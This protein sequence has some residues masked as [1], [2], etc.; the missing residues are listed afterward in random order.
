MLKTIIKHESTSVW[1]FSGSYKNKKIF[2]VLLQ[3][4]GKVAYI[5]VCSLKSAA[6]DTALKDLKYKVFICLIFKN[7]RTRIKVILHKWTFVLHGRQ[8]TLKLFI[9]TLY[10]KSSTYHLKKQMLIWILQPKSMCQAS[11][12]IVLVTKKCTQAVTGNETVCTIYIWYHMY[13]A[14]N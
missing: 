1:H 10:W 4:V 11:I 8:N 3:V 13:S 14:L 12:G 5:L 7:I 9:N 2:N 6:I